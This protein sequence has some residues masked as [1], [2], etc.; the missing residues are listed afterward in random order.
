MP[1]SPE[2]G[3]WYFCAKSPARSHTHQG[4]HASTHLLTHTPMTCRQTRAV[5]LTPHK[6]THRQAHTHTHNKQTPRGCPSKLVTPRRLWLNSVSPRIPPTPG[7]SHGQTD[8]TDTGEAVL[9]P[10]I[11]APL[12]Q[13]P[14]PLTPPQV[15]NLSCSKVLSLWQRQ[16]SKPQS[17]G[18]GDAVRTPE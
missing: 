8:R 3:Q 1:G 16:P 6:G 9:G 13:A 7:E 4:P 2:G 14:A 17:G 11:P 15:S 18:L 10:Q 12:S 5:P